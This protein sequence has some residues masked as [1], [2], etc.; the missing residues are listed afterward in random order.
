MG[1]S[2]HDMTPWFDDYQKFFF[3]EK[4][5]VKCAGATSSAMQAE[6]SPPPHHFSNGPSLNILDLCQWNGGRGVPRGFFLLS[7]L[8]TAPLVINFPFLI[9]CLKPPCWRGKT[10]EM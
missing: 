1:T 5:M 6:N 10:T 2:I 3:D 8:V 7:L 9:E 4:Y